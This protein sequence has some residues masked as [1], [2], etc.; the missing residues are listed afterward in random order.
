M[1]VGAAYIQDP[2]TA[3]AGAD[4]AMDTGKDC[5]HFPAPGFRQAVLVGIV[6]LIKIPQVCHTGPGIY[7]YIT[8]TG[9]AFDVKIILPDHPLSVTPSTHRAGSILQRPLGHIRPVE[10]ILVHGPEVYKL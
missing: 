2:A 1:S 6:L 9:T 3:P 7:K 4:L 10:I 8:A 5:A